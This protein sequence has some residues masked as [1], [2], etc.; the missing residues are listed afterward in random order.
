[1]KASRHGKRRIRQ[2]I[3]TK[4][5]QELI[6]EVFKFGVDLS[7]TKRGSLR[8]YLI[9]QID[10]QPNVSLRVYKNMVYMFNTKRQVV[11]TTFS[12]PSKFHKTLKKLQEAKKDIDDES[13]RGSIV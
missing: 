3:G 7:D 11:I 1:M 5:D 10:N 12:V 4:N 8:A 2:R 9:E 6:N 13:E